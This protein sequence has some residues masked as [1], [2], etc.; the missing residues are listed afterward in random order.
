M[1]YLATIWDAGGS[2]PPELA[3]IRRLTAQGH[4]VTVLAGPPLRADVEAI[5]ATFR[6]W[7]DVPHRRDSTEPDPFSNPA[8]RSPAKIVRRLVD[9]LISGPADQYALE[10]GDALDAQPADALV[11]SMLMLGGM[12]AAEARGLPFVPVFPNCYTMM[13]PGLPPFGTGW[14]PPRTAVGRLRNSLILAAQLRLWD[15]GLPRFNAV[16]SSLGLPTLAHLFDQHHAAERV[17]V[18][19]S[20]AFD[21]PAPLP[22]NV[23]YVG[24]QLDDPGW[25][26]PAEPPPGSE[27]LIL[28]GL[29]S[30]DMGQHDLLRRIV[31]ALHQLP[32]RALVTTGPDIDP[33]TLPASERVSIVRSAPHSTLLPAATAVINHGGHGTVVKT[34]AAGLPQLVIPLGRDQPNNAARVIA[35]AVGLRLSKR[36]TPDAIA[37]SLTRLLNEP[38][39]ARKAAQL[40]AT[41]SADARSTTLEDELQ[42]AADE[43]RADHV[44]E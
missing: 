36:A 8:D 42:A 9:E 29:S 38:D 5:G 12:A 7:R 2:V 27:P 26:Q 28:V 37:T 10:V 19:S 11:S 15:R 30:T 17:L 41:I 24:A 6:A 3:V 31:A 44:A 1:K 16:R 35:A 22:P 14:L 43:T 40:G 23:R 4:S 33:A 20:Q 39:H 34:L 32:V 18:L 13:T 21:F 25:V